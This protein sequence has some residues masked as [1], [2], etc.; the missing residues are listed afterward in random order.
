M[1]GVEE[2]WCC[3]ESCMPHVALGDGLHGGCCTVWCSGVPLCADLCRCRAS[4]M[5]DFGF[6][7]F[8]KVWRSPRKGIPEFLLVF[9]WSR[10]PPHCCCW[11]PFDCWLIPGPSDTMTT[12]QLKQRTINN[13]Q[14]QLKQRT[15]NNWQS[16]RIPRAFYSIKHSI[17]LLC[18][19]FSLFFFFTNVHLYLYFWFSAY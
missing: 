13:W 10:W 9:C 3:I 5:C 14:Y 6:R 1:L 11:C 7:T 2:Q 19:K 18:N 17:L 12:D 15:I 16:I 8:W 4:P